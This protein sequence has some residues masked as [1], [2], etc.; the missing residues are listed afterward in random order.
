MIIPLYNHNTFKR[1]FSSMSTIVFDSDLNSETSTE[2]EDLIGLPI[3]HHSVRA[4][5]NSKVKSSLCRNFSEF[6]ICPYGLKCQFAHGLEEL[7]CNN[8]HSSS[9]K[10]KPC[11]SFTKKN[12]CRYG[13]RCN[14]SHKNEE[15]RFEY[16]S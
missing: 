1:N 2:G 10:T 16:L 12:Y 7:R 3:H 13:Y 11:N 6:G 14:F 4:H 8:E 15:K 9:Y 5:K